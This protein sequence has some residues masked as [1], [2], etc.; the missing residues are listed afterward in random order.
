M[1]RMHESNLSALRRFVDGVFFATLTFLI[2]FMLLDFHI[3]NQAWI[4]V[5][6]SFV[7]AEFTIAAA[8]VAL[9]GNRI[10]IAQTGYLEDARRLNSLIAA[11]AVLPSILS[12]L[13]AVATNNLLLIFP[14][15]RPP[16]GNDIPPATDFRRVPEEILPA[17]KE[18]IQYADPSSQER[19]ANILRHFQI[20]EARRGNRTRAVLRPFLLDNP[21]PANANEL[22]AISNAIGWA[23]IHAL[24]ADAY[25]FARRS[26]VSIPSVVSADR[27]RGAFLLAGIML[28]NYPHLQTALENRIARGRL[29]QDWSNE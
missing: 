8:W 25:G 7:V 11:R 18:C 4:G 1:L 14:D 9:R 29:E 16:R 26:G 22:T 13:T 5:F 28:D 17:F 20:Y 10:Q 2:L 15:N 21:P 23:V 12:E 19:L 6:G 3:E 27:V 24:V